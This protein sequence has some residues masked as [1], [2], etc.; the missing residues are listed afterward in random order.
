[1]TNR[2]LNSTEVTARQVIITAPSNQQ[3]TQAIAR[4][5]VQDTILIVPPGNTPAPNNNQPAPQ[6]QQQGTPTQNTAQNVGIVIAQAFDPAGTA[7]TPGNGGASGVN[8]QAVPTGGA[9]GSGNAQGTGGVSTGNAQSGGQGGQSNGQGGSS[10]ALPAPLVLVVGGQQT[11]IAPTIIRNPDST[12]S[13]TAFVL[14]PGSTLI[15]GGAAITVSG[16]AVSAPGATT[17]GGVGGAIASGLGYTGPLA[18]DSM[19]S[20]IREPNMPLWV[21]GAVSGVLGA[22]AFGL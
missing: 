10:G 5:E 1:L 2:D 17:T 16:T 3:T 14:G 19:A 21:F 22:L 7:G 18:S 4:P 13:V 11:S 8:G 6:N 15:V 9:A 12:G 20:S